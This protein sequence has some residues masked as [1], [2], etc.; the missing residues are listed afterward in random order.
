[1]TNPDEY[2][3][4]NVIPPIAWALDLYF[5]QGQH[6]KDAS[7]VEV[8]FPAGDHKEALRTVGKHEIAVWLSKQD[9]FVRPRCTYDKDCRFMTPR[10]DGRDR[11]AVKA[12]PW[13]KTDKTKFFRAIRDWLLRMNLDYAILVRA[14][15]TV[16]DRKVT[17]PLTTRWKKKFDKFDDYR[18]IRWPE[19]ATPDNRPRVIEEVLFRV[20][21]WFQTAADVGALKKAQTG[22]DS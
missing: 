13:D 17:I 8:A 22:Q 9:V 11:D 15:V 12:L 19:D 18:R 3:A 2:Y 4:A 16:C 1:M 14:L 5:K 20:A 7:I 21:F 10:I 6:S